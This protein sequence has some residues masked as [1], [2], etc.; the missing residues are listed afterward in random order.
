VP[1]NPA[2]GWTVGFTAHFTATVSPALIREIAAIRLDARVHR[3]SP[4]NKDST[5]ARVATPPVT[6][7][8][9]ANAMSTTAAANE[10]AAAHGLFS[11]TCTNCQGRWQKQRQQVPAGD[12]AQ[13]ADLIVDARQQCSCDRPHIVDMP[14]SEPTDGRPDRSAVQ[15]SW[16]SSAL[17]KSTD[18][19]RGC[20]VG[21]G[22]HR[23]RQPRDCPQDC[24][25]G[26]PKL[27]IQSQRETTRSISEVEE[28]EG[29][30]KEQRCPG[31]GFPFGKLLL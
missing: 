22:S 5:L 4:G 13:H 6:F 20:R 24:P 26:A 2:V 21:H 3:H 9:H 31:G 15:R 18:L 27:G 16:Q 8:H 1:G 30:R 7:N 10:T 12:A 23:V 19:S 11:D 29:F 25:D 17:E 28:S 14:R